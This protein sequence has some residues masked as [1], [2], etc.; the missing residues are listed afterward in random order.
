LSPVG[1]ESYHETV[2]E[3]GPEVKS[4]AAAAFVLLMAAGAANGQ[5]MSAEEIIRQIERTVGSKAQ[6]GRAASVG[7]SRALYLENGVDAE[8]MPAEFERL[9]PSPPQPARPSGDAP[10]S[11]DAV[12]D[13]RTAAVFRQI[14]FDRGSAKLMNDAGTSATVGE[15]AKALVD[16]RF[17]NLT[18][19][20]RGHTD[21]TGG[22]RI[23]GPLSKARAEAVA[24]RLSYLGVPL[25]RLTARGMASRVPADPADP[26]SFKNRR[27]DICV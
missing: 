19:I 10:A 20:V 6:P 5:E 23:N 4:S 24:R 2:S 22:P 14:L 3:K 15:L 7:D 27:V 21:A 17:A 16:P 12:S 1:V 9:A 26:N 8:R 13:C 11:S 18:F 25:S